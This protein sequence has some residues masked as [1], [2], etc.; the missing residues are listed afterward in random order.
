MPF[1]R[2]SV[3][4]LSSLALVFDTKTFHARV[5]ARDKFFSPSAS[6]FL[7]QYPFTNAPYASS[8]RT[9]SFCNKKD[10][11]KKSGIIPRAMLI[12][13]AEDHWI[14]KNFHLV[15]KW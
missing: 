15:F 5:V 9:A 11:W 8:S 12:L 4:C 3:T 6:G 14:G 7:C 13:K 1:L 10:K 2:Q